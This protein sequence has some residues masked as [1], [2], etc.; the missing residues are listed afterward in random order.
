MFA[1][2]NSHTLEFVYVMSQFRDTVQSS[3]Y[4]FRI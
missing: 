2:S 1:N 4:F 3:A